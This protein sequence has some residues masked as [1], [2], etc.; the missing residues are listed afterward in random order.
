MPKLE[1]CGQAHRQRAHGEVLPVIERDAVGA[2]IVDREANGV[3][4][5]M[6]DA[7]RVPNLLPA[8]AGTPINPIRPMPVFHT[9]G[10]YIQGINFGLVYRW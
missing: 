1:R 4:D 2:A 8:G 6:I 7:A 3:I 9:S 10:Y 5:P